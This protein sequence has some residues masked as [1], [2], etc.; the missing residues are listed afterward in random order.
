VVVEV[1]VVVDVV[2]EVVIVEVVVD[3]VVVVVV[4]VVEVDVV[5]VLSGIEVLIS[6]DAMV[7]TVSTGGVFWELDDSGGAV[8]I[9][10]TVGCAPKVVTSSICF[11]VT[12]ISLVAG[13]NH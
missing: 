9:S 10:G 3:V 7:G 2:V 12:D 13:K 11:V 1:V 5:D 4:V 6:V 8:V